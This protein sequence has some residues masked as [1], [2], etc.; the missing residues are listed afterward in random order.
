MP[1]SQEV[2]KKYQLPLLLLSLVSNNK[3][4]VDVKYVSLEC[5][6][7]YGFT[8]LWLSLELQRVAE[9]STEF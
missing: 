1:G 9:V 6:F 5:L 3:N 4:A 8:F 7:L 2:L